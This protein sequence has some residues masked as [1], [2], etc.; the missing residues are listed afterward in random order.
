MSLLVGAGFWKQDEGV[1]HV[2]RG[3]QALLCVCVCVRMRA[4]VQVGRCL[5]SASFPAL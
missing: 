2:R 5:S 3:Y 4:C 1:R